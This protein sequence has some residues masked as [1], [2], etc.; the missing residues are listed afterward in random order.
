[1]RSPPQQ[2]CPNYPQRTRH[3]S[4]RDRS[5]I[6]LPLLQPARPSLLRR[7]PRDLNPRRRIRRRIR[8][9][10]R[11]ARLFVQLEVCLL[12]VA[13]AV[14]H[15]VALGTRLQRVRFRVSFGLAAVCAGFGRGLGSCAWGAAG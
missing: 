13:R 7:R 5:R 9:R 8:L 2:R 4:R 11:S 14:R 6:K 15:A 3:I 10:R 12:A 1:M